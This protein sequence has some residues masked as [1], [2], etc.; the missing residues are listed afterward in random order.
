MWG[1]MT[2]YIPTVCKSGRRVPRVPHLIEHAHSCFNAAQMAKIYENKWPTLSPQTSVDKS[3]ELLEK[4]SQLNSKMSRLESIPNQ[5]SNMASTLKTV[6]MEV[7]Q[8]HKEMK[9]LREE[10]NS[11]REKNQLLENKISSLVFDINDLEQYGRRQNL[12]IQ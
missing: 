11:L 4:L 6:S 7:E 9:G 1:Y 5:I 8:L 3:E 12:E 10:N 2:Y